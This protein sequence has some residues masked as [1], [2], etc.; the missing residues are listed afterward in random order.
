MLVVPVSDIH[1]M[2]FTD[3]TPLSPGDLVQNCYELQ[4]VTTKWLNETLNLF[5]MS[6]QKN[7]CHL[8]SANIMCFTQSF[9][10]VPVLLSCYVSCHVIHHHY[11]HC[12]RSHSSHSQSHHNMYLSCHVYSPQF[13]CLSKKNC[14][15]LTLCLCSY[16]TLLPSICSYFFHTPSCFR[17]F[18]IALMYMPITRIR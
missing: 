2:N 4:H 8:I 13:S 1:W 15:N 9:K 12:E 5:T 6:M 10:V 16:F 3:I 7:C 18:F 17:L 14:I 11:H